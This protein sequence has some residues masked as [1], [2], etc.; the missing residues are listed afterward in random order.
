MA[1]NRLI[2]IEVAYAQADRQK[3]IKLD[4]ERGST[5][6]DVIRCSGILELFPE[7]DLKKCKVGVFSK[8]REL[9]EP[10]L[11]GDRVEIYRPL[12]IDPKEA[13]RKKGKVK[14]SRVMNVR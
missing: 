11:G 4:V 2:N 8:Q 9:D 14:K 1:T 10:V 13:R 7:I 5:I 12:L 6:L 3:I